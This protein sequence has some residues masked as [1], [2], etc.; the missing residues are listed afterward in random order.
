M[1]C[2][3]NNYYRNKGKLLAKVGMV[4]KSIK[5]T[6]K[7]D[8][9][10]VS[11][12]ECF[13]RCLKK[14]ETKSNFGILGKRIRSLL[15][16]IRLEPQKVDDGQEHYAILDNQHS[17]GPDRRAIIGIR[18]KGCSYARSYWGGCSVCGHVSS[19]L[20][21]ESFSELEITN[22]FMRSIEAVRKSK[23]RTVCLYTSGSFFDPYELSISIRKK[24]LIEISAIPSVR[25][26]VI[27]SLPPFITPEN[28]YNMRAI[29]PNKKIILG[30]GLDS[31]DDIVRS[32]LFQR[33]IPLSDYVSAIQLCQQ[34][35]IGTTGYVVLGHPLMRISD[36]IADSA[37]SIRW[38]FTMGISKVSIEPIALQ[39]S[40]IQQYLWTK[41]LYKLPTIW[42]I[43][44]LLQACQSTLINHP[45]D[46]TLGGQIFTP[47]PSASLSVCESCCK[48]AMETISF[49]P[50]FLWAGI[51]L[52]FSGECCTSIYSSPS[53]SLDY[54]RLL[55]YANKILDQSKRAVRLPSLQIMEANNRKELTSVIY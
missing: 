5:I 39:P 55:V 27:E 12:Q 36:S 26:I 9:D 1:K 13:L 38:L 4:Q 29:V 53:D 46:I 43:V 34:F 15:T 10:S 33:Q 8:T 28:L 17:G 42:D 31:S 41:G 35:N 19:T 16:R 25:S 50:K 48:H 37:A 14:I 6:D 22:D 3:H 24:I 18:T 54:N 20:W 7:N 45:N 23:V 32:I 52:E 51:P 47:L 49:L 21:N 11:Q 2:S 30:I 44:S 40:T